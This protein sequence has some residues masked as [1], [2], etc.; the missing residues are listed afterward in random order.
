M[1]ALRGRAPG[2]LGAIVACVLGWTSAEASAQAGEPGRLRLRITSEQP[3]LHLFSP[4]GIRAG[5][6][7]CATPCDTSLRGPGRYRLA[8]GRSGTRSALGYVELS[9][10]SD[11]RLVID[12]ESREALRVGGG[13]AA[14]VLIA[15]GLAAVFLG[16]LA[17]GA[18]GS[19]GGVALLVGGAIGTSVGLGLAIGFGALGDSV[20]VLALPWP[21][22]SE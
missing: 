17:G 10:R 20:R 8:V 1:R 12:Y 4:D 11:A 5:R 19:E 9:L 3:D 14:G 18:D 13:I 7:L 6:P 22:A 15:A 2:W 21:G 16:A